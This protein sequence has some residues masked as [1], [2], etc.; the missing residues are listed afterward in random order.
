MSV[1]GR[2]MTAAGCVRRG[3]TADVSGGP[4][5]GVYV[6]GGSGWV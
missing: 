6:A 1:E 3:G 2:G 5:A 4:P